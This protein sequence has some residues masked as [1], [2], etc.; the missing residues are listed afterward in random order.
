MRFV[1]HAVEHET[2]R[3]GFPAYDFLFLQEH[4]CGVHVT[5]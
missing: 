5:N 3:T 1:R 2:V 4:L